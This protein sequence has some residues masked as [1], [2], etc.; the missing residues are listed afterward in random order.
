M[1]HKTKYINRERGL[2]RESR[3][4]RAGLCAFMY[5]TFILAPTFEQ[6]IPLPSSPPVTES[7]MLSQLQFIEI[8]ILQVNRSP[9]FQLQYE[10]V[11]VNSNAT[12]IKTISYYIGL[13]SL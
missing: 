2:N 3:L 9:Y 13:G 4:P 10:A 1:R 5:Q 8:I 12:I 6:K 11:C 7:A